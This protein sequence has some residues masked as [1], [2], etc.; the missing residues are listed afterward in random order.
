MAAKKS[1]ILL[2]IVFAIV[3]QLSCNLAANS[4][5]PDTFAT[6]NGLYTAS[7]LTLAV[8]AP[9]ASFTVT[10]GLPLPTANGLPASATIL[11]LSQTPA[12]ALRCDAVQFLS[13]V[14]Y[15]DGSFIPRGASFVKIWRIKNI[16]VCAWTPSYALVFWG[17]DA[18]SAPSVVALTKTV[19]P[20][21]SIDLAVTL[22]AP[23]HKGNYRGYWK[24]QNASGILFGFGAQADT[25][26]WADIKVSGAEYAAYSFADSY[27][28]AS[29]QNNAS[30]LACPGAEGQSGGFVLKLNAPVME[31]G[32]TEDEPGLL[33]VPQDV[34]NGTIS[35][36]YPAIAIQSGD[37]FRTIINCQYQSKKC[38]VVFRLDYKNN[39]QI[40]TLA[41]WH[42]I[43][44]GK[45]YPV[46]LDLSALAGET[47]KLILVVSA[48][49]AQ[50]GDRAL[51]LNPHILRQGTPPPTATPTLT[52]TLT[53]T[54]TATP[55]FTAAVTETP[56]AILTPTATLT[57][58]PTP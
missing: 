31:D 43:Y 54:A 40:Q 41:A 26:F 3:T 50:K 45:Y 9:P 15:P 34:E 56:T 28:E 27:C 52:F 18:M 2:F 37:R 51:W 1:P 17:G 20:G 44:E 53:P 25:A 30:A 46:D 21:E 4:A 57:H 7:A 42:E 14:T 10:P 6:L 48:N 36:Q 39:G 35:G 55:T 12:P 49:G 16:G 32:F 5:T 8:G 24:L 19:Y 47:V 58:T 38:D 13:D 11:P 23:D 22:R 29:W 33:T